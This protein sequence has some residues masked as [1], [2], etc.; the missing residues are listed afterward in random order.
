MCILKKKENVYMLAGLPLLPGRL[1]E[2]GDL[3]PKNVIRVV[4]FTEDDT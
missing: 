4:T 2:K 3:T 1:N